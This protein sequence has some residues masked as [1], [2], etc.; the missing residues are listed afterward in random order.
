[1]KKF[2]FLL[3]MFGVGFGLYGQTEVGYDKEEGIAELEELHK[4]VWANL[5][6]IEGYRIQLL[7]ASGVNSRNSVEQAHQEF[8]A[9]FPDIPS[10]VSYAEPYFRLRVGNFETK[11]EAHKT[12][13]LL[14]PQYAGAFVIKDKIEYK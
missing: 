9:S 2:L 12:L 11:L 4:F 7:A 14:R 5:K 10:Y 13:M 1:M 3:C 8:R 6:E